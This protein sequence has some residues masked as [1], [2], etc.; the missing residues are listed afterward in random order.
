MAIFYA[1][2]AM[3]ASRDPEQLQA[4]LDIIVGLF[5]RV[6]L[7]TNTTKTKVMTCVPG[8]IRTRHA[9]S[10]YN[11]MQE[12]LVASSDLQNRS[13]DCDICGQTFQENTLSQHLETQHDVYRSRVIDRDLLVEREP[14]VY[15]A[16]P[17]SNGRLHCPVPGCAGSA[18]TKWTLWQ[19]FG[20]RHPL[21]FVSIIGKGCLPKCNRCGHQVGPLAVN[22]RSTKTC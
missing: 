8:K 21:D 3:L 13:V 16:A 19:H 10:V 17:S 9:N 14:V 2:D 4:A 6:G 20:L 7:R 18:T 1:D 22:H 5:E 12:G 11:G 15:D